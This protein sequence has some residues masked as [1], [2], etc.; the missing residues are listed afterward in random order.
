[1][2]GRLFGISSSRR[3]SAAVSRDNARAD[4]VKGHFKCYVLSTQ[5]L[6]PLQALI[7]DFLAHVIQQRLTWVRCGSKIVQTDSRTMA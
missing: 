6:L 2:R 5:L 1:M 7:I 3:H 4:L